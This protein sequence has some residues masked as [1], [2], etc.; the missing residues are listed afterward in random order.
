MK[1]TT[2]EVIYQ[3]NSTISVEALPAY[4]HPVVIK[5]S[6]KRNASRHYVRSLEREYEMTRAL[7]AVEGVR[8]ALGQQSIDNQSALILEYI[9]GGTLRDLVEREA[10]DLRA[11]S[12][13]AVD[14]ARIL[15]SAPCL[16][17]EG[18]EAR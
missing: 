11:R 1:T 5:R 14:L 16:W 8:Q 18:G 10:L 12:E 13:I 17:T 7:D 4:S 15:G 2:K 3:G 9:E 6:S